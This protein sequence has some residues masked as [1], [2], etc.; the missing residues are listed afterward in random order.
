MHTD[1]TGG[2]VLHLLTENPL[3]VNIR[4]SFALPH[5]YSMHCVSSLTPPLPVC[6]LTP[7][8]S[9]T[10][11]FL[12]GAAH[13][14]PLPR[15]PQGQSLPAQKTLRASLEIAF[16]LNTVKLLVLTPSS[17]SLCRQVKIHHPFDMNY[18]T[19]LESRSAGIIPLVV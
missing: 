13:P 11:S 16:S 8:Q 4:Y 7:S 19:S 2:A 10:A 9:P 1:T 17:T 6:P 12:L 14:H 18:A 3:K 15:P 5:P